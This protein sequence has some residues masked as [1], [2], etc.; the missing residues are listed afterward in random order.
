[1]NSCPKSSYFKIR[2]KRVKDLPE[3]IKSDFSVLRTY[4]LVETSGCL[5]TPDVEVPSVLF[6]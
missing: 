4:S 1:M 5:K 6:K 3:L 2:L